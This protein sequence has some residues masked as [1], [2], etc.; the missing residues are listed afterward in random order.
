MVLTLIVILCSIDYNDGMLKEE[1][2]REAQKK[3]KLI[4]MSSLIEY[5]GYCLCCGSQFAGFF[6]K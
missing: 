3:N 6:M 5:F 2:L 4:E 1:G